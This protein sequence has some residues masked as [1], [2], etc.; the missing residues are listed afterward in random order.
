MQVLQ[1]TALFWHSQL[2]SFVQVQNKGPRQLLSLSTTIF[3]YRTGDDNLSSLVVYRWLGV[4]IKNF[5]KEEKKQSYRPW[6]GGSSRAPK[7]ISSCSAD[8]SASEE[9]GVGNG[10]FTTCKDIETHTHV[11]KKIK[12]HYGLSIYHSCLSV[13]QRIKNMEYLLHPLTFSMLRS[14]I[15]KTRSSTGRRVISASENWLKSLNTADEYSLYTSHKTSH[16]TQA[17]ISQITQQVIKTQE[18]PTY[19]NALPLFFLP[20]RLSDWLRPETSRS[21]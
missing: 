17:N 21:P 16:H 9:G 14:F 2:F 11:N 5:K 20:F 18:T 13:T 19:S 12:V 7:E 10:K 3:F 4:S 15:C 1:T 6:R 8:T